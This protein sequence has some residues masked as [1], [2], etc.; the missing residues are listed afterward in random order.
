MQYSD[1]VIVV[2]KPEPEKAGNS[3]EDKTQVT[4]SMVSMAIAAQKVVIDAKDE[5]DLKRI[6]ELKQGIPKVID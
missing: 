6:Q 2:I 1:E 4:W 5:R 3:P